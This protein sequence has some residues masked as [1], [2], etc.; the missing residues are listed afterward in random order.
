[1]PPANNEIKWRKVVE[2]YKEA[3]LKP[4]SRFFNNTLRSYFAK[5]SGTKI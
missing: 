5:R 2:K 4:Q 1:M 3:L